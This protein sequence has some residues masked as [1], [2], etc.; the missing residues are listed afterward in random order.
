MPARA[1][2]CPRGCFQPLFRLKRLRPPAVEH[3]GDAFGAHFE[4]RDNGERL[5]VRDDRGVGVHGA[6]ERVLE[7][8]TSDLRIREKRADRTID[9]PAEHFGDLLARHERV[10]ALLVADAGSAR[11]SPQLSS[12]ARMAA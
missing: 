11:R 5:V 6:P 10:F 3:R 1:S 4:L 12:T 8:G 2:T 7:L 9:M